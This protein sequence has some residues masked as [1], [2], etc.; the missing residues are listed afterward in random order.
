MLIVR[1]LVAESFR[2]ARGKVLG[3]GITK[4]VFRLLFPPRAFRL[5]SICVRGNARSLWRFDFAAGSFK[6]LN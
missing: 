5:D 2:H 1:V 6:A 4:A 3:V